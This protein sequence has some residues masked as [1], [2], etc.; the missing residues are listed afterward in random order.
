MARTHRIWPKGQPVAQ[1]WPDY[2]TLE[3]LVSRMEVAATGCILISGKH[4]YGYGRI[5]LADGRIA[6]AHRA[7][8]E[9]FVGPIPNGMTIDHLC[10]TRDDSC[11]GGKE[12]PHRSCVNPDHLEVVTLAENK[13]RGRSVAALNARKTHCRY[14]HEFT[15]EN[16]AP[17]PRGGRSCRACVRLRRQQIKAAQISRESVRYCQAPGCD[18]PLPRGSRSDRLTCSPSCRTRR[19]R[20]LRGEPSCAAF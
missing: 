17:V 19:G 3:R 16:T 5:M 7:A 12:C 13:R 10:H 11:P 20:S 1:R 6:L 8:Y 4:H 18:N 14:G 2:T 15:P 9:A